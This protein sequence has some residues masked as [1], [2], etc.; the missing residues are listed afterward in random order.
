MCSTAKVVKPDFARKLERERNEA[1]QQLAAEQEN[2]WTASL[3]DR[4]NE[5]IRE[6]RVCDEVKDG[7]SCSKAISFLHGH[8]GSLRVR[9]EGAEAELDQLRK[10][11]DE[12]AQATRAEFGNLNWRLDAYNNLPHVKAK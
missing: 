10:V 9:K 1:K 11:C 12:L 2:N 4:V 6:H 8:A 5:F 7:P 3:C